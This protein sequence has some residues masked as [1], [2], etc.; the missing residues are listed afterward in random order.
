MRISLILAVLAAPLASTA[1]FADCPAA[2]DVRREMLNLVAK[3]QAA[4]TF[5]DGR[6]VSN[7]MWQ[8]WL[9]AP[10]E[11]AQA[12]LDKGMARR[13]VA[14]FAGAV[15]EFDRLVAYCPEYAEG[16]NQ[17]AY[18]AFLQTDYEKALADLDVALSLQPFHVAAQAGRA[19][20]LMN[21]GRIKEAR[22][23]MLAAVNNNPWL[24]E[25]ALLADGAPL[26]LPGKEL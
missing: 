9:R 7:Q 13:D 22:T 1:S 14:D 26:G 2:P 4:E 8:V 21:M 5:T 17:R 19:L 3:A 6:R 25:R 23:Q 20:T 24:S 12:V 18:I 16:W 10:N 11:Q 15:A